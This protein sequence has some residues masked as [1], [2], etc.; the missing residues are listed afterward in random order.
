MPPPVLDLSRSEKP[1]QIQENLIAYMRLF[2]GLPGMVM[3]DADSFWFVSGKPAP[4]NVILRT[5]WPD[6]R[7]EERIDAMLAQISQHIDQMDWM[8]FPGDQPANLSK[9]LEA[10]GMPGGPGGNWLWADLSTLDF[11]APGSAMP[12]NF[13]IEPVRDDAMMAEWVRVSESRL[14]RGTGVVLRCLR[15]AWLRAGRILAALHRLSG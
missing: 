4:G 1:A 9:R 12:G 3:H 6:D 10:R 13:H 15:P 14:W 7:V 2:A 5:R 11:N 8:V